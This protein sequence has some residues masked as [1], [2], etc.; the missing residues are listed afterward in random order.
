MENGDAPA[1]TLRATIIIPTRDRRRLLLKCLDCLTAQ[2]TKEFEVIIIDDNSTDDTIEA[3]SQ[4][5]QNL[6]PFPL[7]VLQN[8]TPLGANPSRNRGIKAAKS[9]IIA[10]LDSDCQP[11]TDWLEKLLAGFTSPQVAAVTGLVEDPDPTN[12]YELTFR[13]THRLARPGPASRLVAGNM[14]IRRKHLLSFML[15]DEAAAHDRPG[16][17]AWGCDEEGIYLNLKA[18]GHQQMVVP[19]AIVFHEH[20]YTRSDF[21][22][23]AQRGGRAA[24]RLVHQYHL[25]PRLD[26]IPFILGYCSLPFALLSAITLTPLLIII[27]GL[28]LSGAIAAL[29]YNELAHKGKSPIQT[30]KI[31]PT[32]L[33]YYHLRLYGYIS[34]T[35]A[36]KK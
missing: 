4:F 6:P 2:T 3:L 10:F 7:T 23:Q 32:L 28:F 31:L 25:P 1:T 36:R 16:N 8:N 14:A 17:S 18:E 19:E 30:L 34:E 22:S 20:Y 27:P 9:S 33:L 11:R 13:G 24:A 21:Y 15:D 12:I 5:T 35:I 26:L 29:L